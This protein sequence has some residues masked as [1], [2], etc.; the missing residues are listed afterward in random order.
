MHCRALW[1]VK[2]AS[3]WSIPSFVVVLLSCV[4]SR[5]CKHLRVKELGGSEHVQQPDWGA[6]NSDQQPPEA[7]APQSRV[8][9]PG[10]RS[11]SFLKRGKTLFKLPSRPVLFSMNRLSTL[12]RGFGSLPALE[13]LDLTY[14]NLNHNSLPGNFFYLSE[15]SHSMRSVCVRFTSRPLEWLQ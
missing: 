6:S 14:N 8:T 15:W 12:P 2:Y 13:V 1:A 10:Q 5:A 4:L 3:S 11:F 9:F 7:E